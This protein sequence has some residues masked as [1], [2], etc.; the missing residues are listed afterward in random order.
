MGQE[1]RVALSR[2]IGDWA[3]HLGQR[4][5][6]VLLCGGTGGQFAE[7]AEQSGCSF[8]VGEVFQGYGG[9]KVRRGGIEADADETLF[10]PGGERIDDRAEFYG[11]VFFWGENDGAGTGDGPGACAG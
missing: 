7:E 5:G 9:G 11:P 1:T 6:L 2:E 10:A 8:L 4:H 3:R